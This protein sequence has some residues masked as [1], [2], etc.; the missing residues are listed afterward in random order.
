ML[1]RLLL[2]FIAIL[3]CNSAFSQF[4]W[5]FIN[6]KITNEKIY[7]IINFSDENILFF[8][9][10]FIGIADMDFN[11]IQQIYVALNYEEAIRDISVKDNDTFL[12]AT[13][14]RI[15]LFTK[16]F[17][18]EWKQETVFSINNGEFDK[19]NLTNSKD[20]FVSGFVVKSIIQPQGYT[21]VYVLGSSWISNDGGKT[22]KVF[23]Q[24]TTNG[25]NSQTNE[26]SSFNDLISVSDTS[27]YINY[28]E[29]FHSNDN[30]KTIK[31][32]SSFKPK[33]MLFIND[34][35][36]FADNDGKNLY[37]T[38]NLG[39]SWQLSFTGDVNRLFYDKKLK[40]IYLVSVENYN[41][42]KIY[43]SNDLGNSWNYIKSTDFENFNDRV[44]KFTNNNYLICAGEHGNISVSKNGGYSFNSISD[45][46]SKNHFTSIDFT[47]NGNAFIGTVR[48][49]YYGQ[50]V[51]Y[52]SLNWGVNWFQLKIEN[53]EIDVYNLLTV[54]S[55][56]LILCTLNQNLIIMD[57]I[58]E[59]DKWNEIKSSDFKANRIYHYYENIIAINDSVIVLFDKDLNY[60]KQSKLHILG[61]IKAFSSYS[62]KNNYLIAN[63]GDVFFS[64]NLTDWIQIRNSFLNT[65]DYESVSDFVV[66]DSLNS[67]I[68][69][70]SRLFQSSN[71]FNTINKLD[72]PIYSTF[73]TLF[74]K[75]DNSVFFNNGASIFRT[76]NNGKT[77]TKDLVF[78]E[79]GYSGFYSNQIEKIDFGV[80]ALGLIVSR[81]LERKIPFNIKT[82]IENNQKQNQNFNLS[83]NYPNPFNPSTSVNIA[84]EKSGSYKYEIINSIGQI[85]NQGTLQ[86]SNP[87]SYPIQL[88]LNNY[89]SGIYFYRIS[90]KQNSKS[91]K[92]ILLK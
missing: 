57:K 3:L 87:G 82:M 68:V 78:S 73:K 24:Q 64:S 89:P 67:S 91:V 48:N 40:K 36:G 41:T 27:T 5:Q 72:I 63:G 70:N 88:N 8:G 76:L 31:K 90:D 39:Q 12:A 44:L 34:N 55:S 42:G 4:Q 80:G 56:R 86:F 32:I 59:T 74:T 2:S 62:D 51:I 61:G 13:N 37:S 60:L 35:L 14:K 65:N 92:M 47:E 66:Y 83:N 28:G 85:I 43:V 79:N 25:Q 52:Q 21:T 10:S 16:T 9:P 75:S 38:A 58:G 49:S 23:R 17:S 54:D 20:A 50:T 46:F 53:S 7:K 29:I 22:W 81:G 15:I 18:Y 45:S 30:L 11:A 33:N 84:V 77:W 71:N 69:S 1:K 6:P 26:F 19:I